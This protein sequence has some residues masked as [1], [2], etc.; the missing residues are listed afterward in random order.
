MKIQ[1]QIGVIGFFSLQ[2]CIDYPLF[3]CWILKSSSLLLNQT[4]TK[5]LKHLFKYYLWLNSWNVNVAE[6]IS[7]QQWLNW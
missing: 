7:K 1:L 6:K 3:V 2:K 5:L 4:I